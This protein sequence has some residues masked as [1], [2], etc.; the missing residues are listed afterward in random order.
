MTPLPTLCEQF[1]AVLCYN[2]GYQYPSSRFL[3]E[4]TYKPIS[5]RLP[6]AKGP[7]DQPKPG[8]GCFNRHNTQ[9][10]SS[11]ASLSPPSHPNDLGQ[12]TWELH[13]AAISHSIV[14]MPLSQNVKHSEAA[15]RRLSTCHQTL[16]SPERRPARMA[17]AYANAATHPGNACACA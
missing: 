1:L 10:Y 13:G 17:C 3:I 15:S 14:G 8:L 9:A 7:A 6:W 2:Q 11:N 12:T 16:E 4:P 5:A